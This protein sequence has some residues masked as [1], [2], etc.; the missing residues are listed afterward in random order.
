MVEVEYLDLDGRRWRLVAVGRSWGT[1]DRPA[2][3]KTAAWEATMATRVGIDL[4][5]CR[6]APRRMGSGS[7]RLASHVGS[8]A[9][10]V[11]MAQE[12]DND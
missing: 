1:L 12:G 2:S 3:V 4:V 6:E 7:C 8:L 5:R 11:V 10:A 9:A